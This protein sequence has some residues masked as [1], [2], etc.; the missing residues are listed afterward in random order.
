MR[1][2]PFA[3]S[4]EDS[5]SETVEFMREQLLEDLPVVTGSELYGVIHFDQASGRVA[6][7]A[8]EVA[9]REF[10][11]CEPETPLAEVLEQMTERSLCSC[12]VVA[13]RRILGTFGSAEVF[14]AL[15]SLLRRR[16]EGA[17]VASNP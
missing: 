12:V 1:P 15:S 9:E 16:S 3:A 4:G 13:E 11:A 7:H 14:D 17:C 6:R 2:C 5:L 8:R 10:L